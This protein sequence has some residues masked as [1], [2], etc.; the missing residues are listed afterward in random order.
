MGLDPDERDSP[1]LTVFTALEMFLAEVSES[2]R[3]HILQSTLPAMAR[4]ALDLRSLRPPSGLHFS[5]QQQRQYT[6]VCLVASHLLLRVVAG[7][8]LLLIFS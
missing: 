4:R 8:T 5:L 7:F 1:D 2:E 3:K 6:V